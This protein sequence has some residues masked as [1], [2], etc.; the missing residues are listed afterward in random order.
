MN[1]VGEVDRRRGARQRDDLALRREHIDLVGEQIDLDV[2]EELARVAGVA[3]DL[4]QR[5][6]PLG[7]GGSPAAT[8]ATGGCVTA[9]P[10][11]R[12]RRPCKASERRRRTRRHGASRACGSETRPACR[13]A[14]S[15]SCA[16]TGNR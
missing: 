13:T 6:P 10:K 15:G 2:L 7:G 5:L 11:D 12:N 8:A 9:A 4:Q 3:L 16:A 14:R 1:P